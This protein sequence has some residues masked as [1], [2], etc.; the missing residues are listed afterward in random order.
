MPP[1]TVIF[2]LDGTLV[3]TAP[4]LVDTLNWVFRRESL[5][6]LP[7]AEARNMIGGGARRMI[8]N[9]LRLEGRAV[10]SAEL[11]RML[12]DFIRYYGEHV[13]DRSRPFPGLD[14][15]LDQ[16]AGHG[17]RFAVCTNK[18]EGL[19]R[20]LLEA[21]KMTHRFEAICGPDTFNIYKPDP[22]ILRRTIHAAGGAM[23]RSIMVGDSETDIA[24]ARAAGVPIV[25]VDFGYSEIPVEKLTPDRLI[26][27]YDQLVPAV[28]ELASASR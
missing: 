8:E 14:A 15:A 6:E 5:P 21:L 13:A 28:L 23:E 1:L 22:E 20:L 27:H 12:A 10:D 18:R 16:L 11:D 4:D 7:Y 24:T 3:E 17:F 25:A 9:G 19:S 2:D 26:S